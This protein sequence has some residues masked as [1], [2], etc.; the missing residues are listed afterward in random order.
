MYAA[1]ST[2]NA[3]LLIKGISMNTPTSASAAS[4]SDAVNTGFNAL[5]PNC[6]RIGLQHAQIPE[7]V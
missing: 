1:M 4:S 2:Q 5:L 6:T 7:P 3:K